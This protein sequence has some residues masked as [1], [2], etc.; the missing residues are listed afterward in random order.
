MQ[1]VSNIFRGRFG[2]Y[3]NYA[4]LIGV[5][6]KHP[7][8]ALEAKSQILVLILNLAFNGDGFFLTS[9][10]PQCKTDLGKMSTRFGIMNRI[11]A[12]EKRVL[13]SA[14]LGKYVQRVYYYELNYCHGKK[15]QQFQSSEV[16]LNPLNQRALFSGCSAG[17]DLL[18]F[19]EFLCLCRCLCGVS[20]CG[21]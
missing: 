21:S 14:D 13:C 19:S 5:L 12:M 15:G 9:C 11:I 4:Y 16:P 18:F 8:H 17:A 20:V 7:W 3:R 10:E 2:V 1:T 6:I